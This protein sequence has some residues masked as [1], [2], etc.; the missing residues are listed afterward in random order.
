MIDGTGE[1]P[2]DD[3][4]VLIQD[5]RIKYVGRRDKVDV[6]SE[7]EITDLSGK[8]IMPG[9]IDAHVHLGSESM[10]RLINPAYWNIVT[11]T[12]LKILHALRN[13]QLTLEAGFTSVRNVVLEQDPWDVSLKQAIE[14]GIARGPRI[15]ASGGLVSMTAGHLDLYIPGNIPREPD[16]TA[17][18]PD[19]VRRAVRERV[20]AGADFIKICTSGGVLSLGDR[21]DWR[22]HTLEEVEAICDE[23]HALKRRVMAHAEGRIGVKNAIKGGVDTLEHGYFIDDEDCEVMKSKNIILVP[24][25]GIS[26]NIME[27]GEELGV[28]KEGVEKL[29][30]FED[31]HLKSVMRAHRS[32]VKIALGTD[33]LATIFSHGEN[34]FE[35]ECLVDVGLS[36]MEAIVAGTRNAAEAIGLERDV[37]TIEEDKQAD[38]IVVDGNPLKDLRILQDKENIRLVIRNG[39][40]FV[41]RGL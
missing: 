36:P 1:E 35:L 27:R 41:N 6:P 13:A 26:R 31:T 23:T 30:G 28:S 37:G 2:L 25:L 32:G 3:S 38:I 22:N 8:T 14:L 18:G 9:L 34:A 11:P 40:T 21:P 5:S 7:A 10:G 20:R 29:R 39:Q 33:A 16:R 15:V 4:A 19:Q 17:D 12:T 24:T